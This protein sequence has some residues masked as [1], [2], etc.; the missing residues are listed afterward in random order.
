MKKFEEQLAQKLLSNLRILADQLARKPKSFTPQWAK[1]ITDSFTLYTR[2][3]TVNYFLALNEIFYENGWP[4]PA[5]LDLEQEIQ[6]THLWYRKPSLLFRVLL[7]KLSFSDFVGNFCIGRPEKKSKSF[8]DWYFCKR[9]RKV[10]KSVFVLWQTHPLLEKK[11]KVLNDVYLSYKKQLWGVCIPSMLPLVDFLMRDYFHS[12]DL[13]DS[14]RILAKAFKLANITRGGL[15]PGYGV[16]DSLE[17]NPNEIRVADT[18]ERDLRL[19]GIYLVSFIDFVQRYYSW[20]K[21]VSESKELNR[22][23]IAHGDMNY[24]SE[25]DTTKFLMFFDLIIKLEPVLRFL[26]G[27]IQRCANLTPA[28]EQS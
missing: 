26:I 5:Y 15:K 8:I 6:S 28:R 21:V 19:L 3:S 20:Y 7:G 16:W 12:D 4:F 24:W 11:N 18:V 13:R 1:S 17:K 9:F 2:T 14:V 27:D 10:A 23:A 25:V 22:H